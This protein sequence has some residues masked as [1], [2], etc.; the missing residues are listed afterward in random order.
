MALIVWEKAYAVGI[1]ALDADHIMIFSLI[2]H[3][4][5][6]KQS[7]T[8][9]SAVGTILK[10]LLN[11]A[12]A[13]FAREEGLLRKYGYPALEQHREMHRMMAAQLEELHDAYLASHSPEIS[14][15]IVGLLSLWLEDHILEADQAYK[16]FLQDAMA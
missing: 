8:D 4:H 13:H 12:K 3:I 10:V 2:N 6:A 9:E 15:E 11:Q 1:E 7:G 5:E 16:G 14:N